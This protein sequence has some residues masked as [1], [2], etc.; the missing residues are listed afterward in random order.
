MMDF[1]LVFVELS[2]SEWLTEELKVRRSEDAL[3]DP[4]R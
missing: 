1:D 2:F 4:E 3:S